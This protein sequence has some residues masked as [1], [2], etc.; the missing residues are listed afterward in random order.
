MLPEAQIKKEIERFIAEGTDPKAYRKGFA[1]GC[2]V[3]IEVIDRIIAECEMPTDDEMQ[4]RH[5]ER[6]NPY[7]PY[8]PEDRAWDRERERQDS[9]LGSEV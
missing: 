6:N 2:R 7:M 8:T 1:E 5:G 4:K 3:P 9:H